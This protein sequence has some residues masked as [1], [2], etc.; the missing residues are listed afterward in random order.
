M[1]DKKIV[2]E[3][4]KKGGKKSPLEKI[5]MPKE[6]DEESKKKIAQAIKQW[7]MEDS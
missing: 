1:S 4:K 2:I 5:N 6:L 7:L 3:K